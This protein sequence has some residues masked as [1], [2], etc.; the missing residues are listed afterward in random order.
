[1]IAFKSAKEYLQELSPPQS[2]FLKHQTQKTG[3]AG[4]HHTDILTIVAFDRKCFNRIKIPVFQNEIK[5]T[6]TLAKQGYYKYHN[7]S[8]S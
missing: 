1:M 3:V 5:L 2:F 8:H 4:L 7:H 6:K